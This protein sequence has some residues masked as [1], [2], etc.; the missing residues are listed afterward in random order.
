MLDYEASQNWRRGKTADLFKGLAQSI[1]LQAAL[2]TPDS[3]ALTDPKRLPTIHGGFH[4]SKNQ[5]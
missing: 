5:K 1:E 2:L 3:S 4:S